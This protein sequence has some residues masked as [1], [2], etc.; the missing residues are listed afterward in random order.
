MNNKLN[1]S[2][3]FIPREYK[4][5]PRFSELIYSG[6]K[7]YITIYE[8]K[9]NSYE[10]L[11]SSFDIINYDKYADIYSDYE[12]YDEEDDIDDYLEFS[13]ENY[14]NSYYDDCIKS[15]ESFAVI[16]EDLLSEELIALFKMFYIL[17]GN[18]INCS[19][20]IENKEYVVDINKIEKE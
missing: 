13:Y 17:K 11:I 1:L 4:V 2:R 19:I 16:D 5:I 7:F 14:K 12:E 3:V 9:A 20:D 8:T 15:I 18:K 10:E 6:E